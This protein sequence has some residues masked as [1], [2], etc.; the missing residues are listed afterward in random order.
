MQLMQR[1]DQWNKYI[2]S[3]VCLYK[4]QWDSDKWRWFCKN[5][6]QK[7]EYDLKKDNE[8]GIG[9]LMLLRKRTKQARLCSSDT[10]HFHFRNLFYLLWM[11]DILNIDFVAM[12]C[13]SEKYQDRIWV[14]V[15][16]DFCH[17]FVKHYHLP[18]SF[19]T[20]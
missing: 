18:I 16:T 13:P 12:H 7:Y 14:Q 5:K 20:A 3:Y 15:T 17:I 8:R 19:D 4:F 11:T 10:E 2:C 6:S 9:L 1:L